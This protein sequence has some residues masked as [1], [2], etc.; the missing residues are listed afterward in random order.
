MPAPPPAVDVAP[1]DAPEVPP[2]VARALEDGTNRERLELIR[3]RDALSD[4]AHAELLTAARGWRTLLRLVWRHPDA[5]V[6]VDGL[7]L[8]ADAGLLAEGPAVLNALS[9]ERPEV[10][11]AAETAA[12]ALAEAADAA[13]R[14]GAGDEAGRRAFVAALAAHLVTDGPRSDAAAGWLAIAASAGDEELAAVSADPAAG[15]KLTAALETN[16]HPGVIRT[17]LGLV[18]L[19]RP[20]RAAL[21]AAGRTDPGFLIP[22]LKTVARAGAGALPGLPPLAWLGEPEGVLN[23]VPPCLQTAIEE[24]ADRVCEGG[25][26]RRAVRLWLIAHGAAAA[27]RAAEPVLRELPADARWD[28]LNAALA[29]SDVDVVA[30]AT[31]LLVIHRVPGWPRRLLALSSHESGAVRAAAAAALRD[32]AGETGA[33]P[34]APR[35]AASRLARSGANRAGAATSTRPGRA[36]RR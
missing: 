10:R 23:A 3:G 8:V 32:A 4:A 33:R 15:P 18:S 9:D 5:A 16:A 27:R 6:R 30:W 35:F 29:S 22:L 25:R 17:L 12:V 11:D 1:E 26:S 31:E 21:R 28:T 24:L 7:R 14:A 20:P 36:A 19:R 34:G 13:V 2:D